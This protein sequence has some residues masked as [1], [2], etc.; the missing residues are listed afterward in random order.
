MLPL[1]LASRVDGHCIIALPA[2]MMSP[3]SLYDFSIILSMLILLVGLKSV[4][5]QIVSWFAP[6]NKEKVDIYSY[7][8]DQHGR[9]RDDDSTANNDPWYIQRHASYNHT[10]YHQRA[11]RQRQSSLAVHENTTNNMFLPRPPAVIP[12]PANELEGANNVPFQTPAAVPVT[13]KDSNQHYYQGNHPLPSE[14]RPP[15]RP[16]ATQHTAVPH[17]PQQSQPSQ[18][19]HNLGSP[20]IPRDDCRKIESTHSD[21]KSPSVVVNNDL[22]HPANE[23]PVGLGL[24]G[25]S[26]LIN[27]NRMSMLVT[28]HQQQAINNNDKASNVP[29]VDVSK[30][31]HE[32][33]APLEHISHS[34]HVNLDHNSSGIGLPVYLPELKLKDLSLSKIIGGGAFGQVWEGSWM[35]TPVAVKVLNAACQ[36]GVP[37]HVM[38]GFEEEVNMLARLRHPNIC[39]FLGSSFNPPNRAIVTELV[40]RGSLWS[41]LRTRGLF[42][43]LFIES[44]G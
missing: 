34:R 41:L 10:T 1:Q 31:I 28:A 30:Q 25:S 40:S 27:L 21:F 32:T 44:L 18:S 37:E 22:L 12:P 43:V 4:V 13:K 24:R 9:D 7:H 15:C 16:N 14:S 2:N 26:P 8:S 29:T 11:L 36:Q 3:I 19:I 38:K 6:A 42:Q 35:G 33:A 20:V 39:M 23:L 5:N 17:L